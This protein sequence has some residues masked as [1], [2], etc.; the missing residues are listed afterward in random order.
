MGW[1]STVFAKAKIDIVHIKDFP[2]GLV[3]YV[4][5]GKGLLRLKQG[6]SGGNEFCFLVF[7]DVPLMK[8]HGDEYICPTC[9]QFISA[10]YGLGMSQNKAIEEL[11]DVFNAPF[12]SVKKSFDDL[13]P[14]FGLLPTGYY[15]LSDEELFPTDGQGNFFWNVS[16]TPVRNSATCSVH[17]PDSF[18]WSSP[19]PKYLFPTQSPKLFNQ[20]RA[21]QYRTRENAR[22]VAYHIPGTYLCALL[23]GHHKAVAAALNTAPVKT[24]VIGEQQGVWNAGNRMGGGEVARYLALENSDFDHVVWP[25]EILET[26]KSYY[27]A[28]SLA[29]LEWA[30]DLSDDRLDALLADK[31]LRDESMIRHVVH[32]LCIT[33]NPRFTEFAI[34]FCKN[35]NY[36]LLWREI[37]TLLATVKNQRVEDFFVEYL[38]NDEGARPEI[39]R[40]VDG[41]F[42]A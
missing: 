32:A 35:D 11:G 19:I 40:I 8:F 23:D 4:E 33:K 22:A 24:L 1:W 42:T 14:L 17:D 38:I 34:S 5:N 6:V 18:A 39:T 9:E 28:Y 16:N 31:T 20:K 13:K 12:V 7:D 30:G 21:E 26:A 2:G 15:S 3:F 25:P 36:V 10:G 37:F 27:D 29:C 41:Y